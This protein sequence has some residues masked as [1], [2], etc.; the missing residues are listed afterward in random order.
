MNHRT[1]A[2]GLGSGGTGGFAAGGAV[3][4]V[5]A[6]LPGEATRTSDGWR[7]RCPAHKDRTPSLSIA[8]GEGGRALVKCHAGCSTSDVMTGL[9]LGMAD[10]MPEQRSRHQPGRNGKS[11]EQS[12]DWQALQEQCVDALTEDRLE[13]LAELLELSPDSLQRIGC[14]WLEDKGCWTFPER[15]ADGRVIGI[16]LRWADGRKGFIKGGKRGLTIPDEVDLNQRPLCCVEGPSDVAALLTMGVEAVGRPSNRGGVKLLATLAADAVDVLVVGENDLKA[17]GASPGIDG[18]VATA[19]ELATVLRRP[20]RWALPPEGAKDVRSWLVEHDAHD[21]KELGR[22]LMRHFVDTGQAAKPGLGAPDSPCEI[23][24]YHPYPVDAL[25]E[26]LRRFVT[27]ASHALGVD[28]CM[29]ALPMSAMLASCIGTTR[30]VRVKESWREPCIIW[31]GVVAESGTKKTPSQQAVLKPLRRIQRRRF[32]EHAQ[33]RQLHDQELLDYE[34]RLKRWKQKKSK[35]ENAPTKPEAPACIRH[36]ISDSTTEGLAPILQNNLRGL[37][38][39]R[40]EL[41]GWMGDMDRYSGS[42]GGDAPRWLS[43]WSSEPI[44]IDRKTSDTIYVDSPAVSITGGVQ[45][46]VLRRMLGIEHREDGMAARFLYAMPADLPDVWTDADIPAQT[47]QALEQIVEGLLE[48]RHDHDADGHPC[49]VDVQL[50]AEAMK[51]YI[52][53]HDDHAQRTGEHTGDLRAA[54]AKMKGYALRLALVLHMA[55][56]VSGEDVGEAI[57]H[58]SLESATKIIDWH[59]QEARRIYGMLEENDE[60]RNQRE[61]VELVRRLADPERGITANDL[62][63]RTRRFQTTVEVEAALDKLVAAGVGEWVVPHGG[64]GGRPT[65][66]FRLTTSR[67]SPVSVSD[68]PPHHANDRG[69]GYGDE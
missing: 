23:L 9:G 55:R 62:R 4:R 51:Q 10:L 54:M 35:D 22:T 36:I 63:R 42:K 52:R 57:D 48:L 59:I 46:G 18:A 21:P 41:A 29:L 27:T 3:D 16:A 24:Q 66:Y 7:A 43:I 69:L 60:G 31:T 61:L 33:L 37:L 47:E 44:T 64:R 32:D 67:A 39:V 19:E 50:D 68:T 38:L 14:G 56:M 6:A 49:P 11:G 30:T 20:I 25:P 58:T 53:W 5:L 45:P 40:D 12:G 1:F 2:T 28:P 65:R 34:E 17:N 8:A 15:D 26:V 13:E